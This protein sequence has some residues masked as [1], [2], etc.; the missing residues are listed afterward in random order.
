M[1]A[2]FLDGYLM[3]IYVT[4]NRM[5]KE[6]IEVPKISK[7][8][9]VICNQKVVPTFYRKIKRPNE[10]FDLGLLSATSFRHGV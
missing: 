4:L 8:F 7:S 2:I 3:K 9:F 10:C 5:A 1:T 6:P